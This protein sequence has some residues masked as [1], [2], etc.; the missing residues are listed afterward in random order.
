[1]DDIISQTQ[2]DKEDV[3]EERDEDEVDGVLLELI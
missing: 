1:V 3:D 2:S